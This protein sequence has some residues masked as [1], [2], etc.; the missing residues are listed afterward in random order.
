MENLNLRIANNLKRIRDERKLS[1]DKVAN[2]TGVSK[3]MLGQIE[4]EESN[5]TISTVW[6]IANGLKISFTDIINPHRSDIVVLSKREVEPLIEDDGKYKVYPIF[7]YEDGRRFEMYSVD[8]EKD[9]LLNAEAHRDGTE[10][11]L[12]VFQG[13]VVV[14]VNDEEHIINKGDSIRFKADKPHGYRNTGDGLTMISM[15]IYYPL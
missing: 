11:F 1:L 2:L 4:R 15:V 7:P 12:T 13:Q 9:G 10:E 6:K 8:I 3:S 5:P 14:S